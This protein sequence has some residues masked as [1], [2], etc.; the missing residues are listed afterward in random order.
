M[1]V[2]LHHCEVPLFG[3]GFYGVDLFFVLSGFLIT[4]LLRA[5]AAQGSGIDIKSFYLRRALRLWPPLILMLALYA[6]A[7]LWFFRGVDVG[8]DALL[9][10]LYLSDYSF[11]FWQMP[12]SSGTPGPLAVEGHF[13][14]LWPMV[15]L[16]TARL[17]GRRLA[18]LLI[19]MALL[20]SLWRFVQL[21]MFDDW[22]NRI[23]FSF[24]TRSS[25]LLVGSA[26][27]AMPW[28]LRSSESGSR[29]SFGTRRSHPDGRVHDNA[30][31]IHLRLCR[32]R[33][34]WGRPRAGNRQH[35]GKDCRAVSQ[36]A[37]GLCRL[38][39][40]FDL[41][42]QLSDLPRARSPIRLADDRW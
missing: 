28:R 5:E 20:V 36:P 42:F 19:A 29:G 7:S 23:Y 41:S 31:A 9:A 25:G 17:N 14:L 37:A 34:D 18:Q 1:L 13:Y 32:C 16:G 11:A 24:D 40:L 26:I 15:I 39:F 10:G 6:T 38:A 21:V 30:L 35:A 8:R 27:A 4:S 12:A 33:H 22:W 3:G 2:L